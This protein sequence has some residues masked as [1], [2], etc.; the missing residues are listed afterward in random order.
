MARIE[1]LTLPVCEE[2]VRSRNS[3]VV[4]RLKGMG[5]EVSYLDPWGETDNHHLREC[6]SVLC[7]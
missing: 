5:K 2:T 4:V 7:I 1:P 6:S 3:R